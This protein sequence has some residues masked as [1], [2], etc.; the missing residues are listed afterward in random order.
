[1]NTLVDNLD[2]RVRAPKTAL[3]G[4]EDAQRRLLAIDGA[5]S[6]INGKL[7]GL[8]TNSAFKRTA[9]GI[10]DALKT[11]P[12]RAPLSEASRA[13]GFDPKDTRQFI[14]REQ[15]KLEQAMRSS[16][17]K[18]SKLR[19]SAH[20]TERNQML[21]QEKKF[22]T[23]LDSLRQTFAG[24]EMRI[25][26]AGS[27]SKVLFQYQ[28]AALKNA[29]G[30]VDALRVITGAGSTT[31]SAHSLSATV[32][33]GAIPLIVPASQI[34]A[35]LGPGVVS[36]AT[37]GATGA[38]SGG[39]PSRRAVGG[40]A[41]SGGALPDA[42]D[43]LLQE[44]IATSAS[45]KISVARKEL[46]AAGKTLETFFQEGE[47]QGTLEITSPLQAARR[48]LAE[49]TA[50]VQAELA[51][52][53][54]GVNDPTKLA[55]IYRKQAS[56]LG[57][58]VGTEEEPTEHAKELERL[59][60][61]ALVSRTRGNVAKLQGRAAQLEQ[62]GIEQKEKDMFAD[63]RRT[64]QYRKAIDTARRKGEKQEEARLKAEKAEIDRRIAANNQRLQA[65]AKVQNALQT[66]Q[67][68]ATQRSQA[69]ALKSS[70]YAGADRHY[71][72]FINSGGRLV[73][74]RHDQA[75]GQLRQRVATMELPGGQIQKVVYEYG[76]AKAMV[77][78]F[79]KAQSEAR[80]EGGYLAGDFV[81]NTAKVALWAASV[82]ALYKTVEL[83]THSFERL[84]E[85]GP[86]IGRLEQVFKGV[87]GTARE[88]ASDVMH[89]AAA[90]GASTEQA[91][92]AAIQWSRLG[93]TR[94]QVNEAVRVSLM[95]A[96]VAQID[97]LDATEK[98][99]GVMQAYGLSVGELR[100]E[101]GEIV[102]ISNSYNVTNADM[103][104]G[105]SRV[106]AVAKQAG[107]PLAELQGL[108]GATIGGTAQSGANIGNMLKSMILALSN[109]ELQQKLRS[110]FRFEPT[111]GG[112]E[113]KPMSQ[114]L[115]D[116][117]V[118]Y[119]HLNQLQRQSLLFTVGGRTQ[120][121]R[122]EAMLDGYVKAQMLAVNAQLHLNTAEKE[123]EKIV[124][125]LKTQL[126]GLVAE[127]ERFVVIQG[128]RGPEQA[129]NG[130]ARALKNVLTLMNSPAGSLL[131]TGFLGMAAAA[132]AKVAM[133]G[134]AL[135]SQTGDPGFLGRSGQRIVGA[136]QSL[137]SLSNA[138]ILQFVGRSSVG[139]FG[140][141]APGAFGRGVLATND[142][143]NQRL[144]AAGS[145]WQ[146]AAM[147]G[148]IA[149]RNFNR[150]MAALNAVAGLTA[151]SLALTAVALSEFLLPLA[152][153]AA[154]IWAFNKGMEA[155]GLSSDKAKAK[156]A[157]FNEEAQKAGAAANAYAEAA[158]ALNTVQRSLQPEHGFQ[159]MRPDDMKKYISQA[160]DLVGLYEPDLTKQE[161]LQAAFKDQAESLRKQGDIA[162]V[163]NLL[164]TER[165]KLSDKRREQL[166]NQFVAIKNQQRA[167]TDEISRLQA[168]QSGAFGFLGHDSRQ[169]HIGE[170]QRQ[171]AELT[172]AKVRNQVDQSDAYQK[173][174][175]YDQKYQ[176]AIRTE[177]MLWESMA[178][179]FDQVNANNPMEKAAL[180]TASLEAQNSAIEAHLK[181]LDEEDTAD[182]AGQ[183]AREQ[184]M[185]DLGEESDRIRTEMMTIDQ[186]ANRR[187]SP[188]LGNA[189]DRVYA[190][191][192]GITEDQYTQFRT[193]PQGE[194]SKRQSQLDEIDQQRK[195]AEGNVFPGPEGLGYA[196]RQSERSQD[197]QQRKENQANIDA[198][199]RNRP[200]INAATQAQ[201]GREEGRRETSPFEVGRD[202]TEK[203]L[204][205]RKGIRQRLQEVDRLPDS[206]E[207]LSREIELQNQLYETQA[208]LRKRS[209]DVE[210][211]INQLIIDRRKEFEHSILGAGPGEML[212]KLAALRMGSGGHMGIGQYLSLSPEVR[213]DVSMVDPR[214]DPQMMD[215]RREQRRYNRGFPSM[216][217]QANTGDR[218]I[219][220]GER[221]YAARIY[222]DAV[223]RLQTGQFAPGSNERTTRHQI[224][225]AYE[226][227][228]EGY[229]GMSQGVQSSSGS[230]FDR[231][232]TD[233]SRTIG[234]LADRLR[235][236]LPPTATYDA[237]AA[238]IGRLSSSASAAADA[239]DRITAATAP[240]GGA[241]G[242]APRNPQSGGVGAG[243]GHS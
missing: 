204:N 145:R 109:P 143:G 72:D 155:L 67:T 144:T 120:S 17:L 65:N 10:A 137:N 162:G 180:K 22:Q 214:F 5:L 182:T 37:S 215:L 104:T 181:L 52:K 230:A 63:M 194:K 193:D 34:V 43:N 6:A 89:V 19:G 208:A 164:E 148:N 147:G 110:Q 75:T 2:F 44:K 129:L 242:A 27:A 76:N 234:Q 42:G 93:L 53:R 103:L 50:A 205:R 232:Q 158:E 223:R 212:R 192:L 236:A 115:S 85:I 195:D 136:A 216:D 108:L 210:K 31:S 59:G 142:F 184:R 231:G 92:E 100:G 77:Q 167:V 224:S 138:A 219:A 66:A 51:N 174:L 190:E 105:L 14:L 222:Y 7:S 179:I 84:L 40:G 70:T 191:Q 15:E 173:A 18:R 96:N 47:E 121:S 118:K 30:P 61:G 177:K 134:L 161:A 79:T 156:L 91:M 151:K 189:G 101:L 163:I 235:Q 203:L 227:M 185:K 48:K 29:K 125:A 64:G 112:E 95:A 21:A 25:S 141:T 228:Q 23:Q 133:T 128:N 154:G 135:K 159:G 74:E 131:A 83:V 209:F 33:A 225:N 32:S 86:Q 69:T 237:A 166:Q 26:G 1:M 114:M 197:I 201:L 71:Q 238:S 213:H 124:A 187:P 169:A 239:L 240:S 139:A 56:Q 153:V 36:I 111:G 140:P 4:L 45:G 82:A 78:S 20:V 122:M 117:F 97:A 28:Q 80:K 176:S 41:S 211:D 127:W 170:L 200:I 199:N 90:N 123:N 24:R 198:Q 168:R 12:K 220:Q 175:E 49:H 13:L 39:A 178:E 241:P 196:R 165:N 38:P 3:P 9:A 149:T 218:S 81:K 126:T 116:L 8:S 68:Q 229:R 16:E 183:T 157:G 106:A 171:Q 113:I 102:Q 99:Q 94:V 172:D 243:V 60:Q 150:G 107:L 160:G 54:S 132:S 206:T 186:V 46:L 146:T 55:S 221:D 188:K 57:G 87:G 11:L 202:E 226:M 152:I 119:Q 35:T 130:I 98:L 88:L 217:A 207:K 62:Q 73:S 233:I 58:F